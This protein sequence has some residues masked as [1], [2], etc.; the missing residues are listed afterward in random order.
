MTRTFLSRPVQQVL[1][2][3]LLDAGSTFFDYG[4]GRGGDVRSLR[5][6]GY[7][8][9]GWDPA[10]AP[11]EPVLEA[12]VVNLGYVVN[13]IEEPDE[14]R[15]ALG[16]A[17]RLTKEV[18]VVSA[19]LDWEGNGSLGEPFK[20]G[21]V[22]KTGTFQ[23]YF[24]QEELRVWIDTTL[25]Q[26]SV[27]AAPGIFYVF[28]SES[29]EQRLLARHSRSSGRQRLGI[30]ELIYKQQQEQL[31]PFAE[32]V[33]E[34][35][36]LPTPADLP[37]ANELIET[38]GSIRAAFALV[39]R[40]TGPALWRD[41]PYGTRR[42]SEVRFEANLEVLQPLIDFLAERG[43]LPH[44]G[45]L[46]EATSIVAEFGS[47]RGAFSLIRRVTGPDRWV[48]FETRARQ[49]FLVYLA[50]SA[51]GGRPMFSQLPT[52]L[53][54]DARDLFGSFKEACLQADRLLYGVGKTEAID[55]ACRA[56]LIGKL[57]P[58]ALYVH[59]EGVS[60]LPAVLRVYA[61]CAETLTGTVENATILKM[62]REKPQVSF[63]SYPSF[64]KD[65]HP[66]LAASIVARLREFTVSYKDFSTRDN[67]PILHR[68]ETF[69]PDGYPNKV[70]FERLTRQEERAGLLD[71]PRIGTRAGW[72]EC[73]REAGFALRGHRLVRTLR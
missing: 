45:E 63:L 56:S 42:A 17:W 30:A 69:L 72:N 62:H 65:P 41:I 16:H 70:K 26:R 39:R 60:H 58:E 43:R 13:V 5:K 28:R 51:F 10:H 59:I 44:D 7:E 14:R 8:A 20:D 12:T 53:Q 40:V 48:E 34:H 31:E 23:K 61:G 33:R 25:R 71:S 38:F 49:D 55:L 22:T 1:A 21:W 36:K 29:A 35:R 4:C 9:S 18:L 52:D 11:S 54:Y 46:P 73:L 6:L 3:G 67:P 27:A 66:L 50:L 15:E 32:W 2:D 64:D 57:T 68:K 24:S 47:V 37:R 19:R